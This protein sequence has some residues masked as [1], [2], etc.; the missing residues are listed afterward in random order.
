MAALP[1]EDAEIEEL[2]IGD[3]GGNAT[4]DEVAEPSQETS[5]DLSRL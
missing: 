2:D 3:L 1:F 5:S 4:E